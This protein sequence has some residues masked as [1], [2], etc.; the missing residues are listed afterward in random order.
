MKNRLAAAFSPLVIGALSASLMAEP[1][2]EKL[3]ITPD[4]QPMT[5]MLVEAAK[6]PDRE[7]VQVPPYPGARIIQTQDASEMEMNGKTLKTLPYIKLL[8]TD[9]MD[10]VV[11]WYTDQLAGYAKKDIYGVAWLFWKG[12]EDF[13]AI[14]MGKARSMPNVMI[15]DASA[16]NYDQ[17]MKGAKTSI[18]ISYR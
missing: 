16:F 11:A 9:P 1:Y 13:D 10:K 7:T 2:A 8:S 15:S 17:D 18:E 3:V 6:V 12:P 4:T 14:D 5:K